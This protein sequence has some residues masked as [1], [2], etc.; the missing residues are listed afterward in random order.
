MLSHVSC[1]RFS[2]YFVFHPPTFGAGHAADMCKMFLYKN[3]AELNTYCALHN[4]SRFISRE[5]WLLSCN[6][7]LNYRNYVVEWM[8]AIWAG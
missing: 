1:N 7:T 2:G 5:A 6:V 4:F 3:A 8:E